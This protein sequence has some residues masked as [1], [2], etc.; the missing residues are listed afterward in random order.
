MFLVLQR[1]TDATTWE[2]SGFD[3]VVIFIVVLINL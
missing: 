3:L 1:T 2:K